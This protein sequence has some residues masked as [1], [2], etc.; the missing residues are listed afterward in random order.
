MPEARSSSYSDLLLSIAVAQ[1]KRLDAR[2]EIHDL[3]DE[4]NQTGDNFAFS[5]DLVLKAGLLL[6]DIGNVGFKVENFNQE[7]MAILEER[8]PQVKQ[9]LILTVRLVASFGFNGQNLRASSAILPIAYYLWRLAPGDRYLTTASF[10]GDRQ[11]V[12]VWLTKSI[13]KSSGIWGSGLDTLLTILRETIQ[14]HGQAEFPVDEIEAQMARR[15]KSLAFEAEEI[16]ELVE[17]RYGDSRT[18]ALLSLLFSFVDFHNRFHIDH[19][20]PRAHFTKPRL[21]RDGFSDIE[22]DRFQID[23]GR[24]REPPAA[25]WHGEHREAT[26]AAVRVACE[27]V[28]GPRQ[29]RQLLCEARPRQAAR[30]SVWFLGFLHVAGGGAATPDL[31]VAREVRPS[32]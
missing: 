28:R 15:G 4:L 18:F 26:D 11:R 29:P 17:L 13:L 25:G 22:I 2:Q 20:F 21:K 5:Q 14:Q 27:D 16:E 6:T 24:A 12:R 10:S 1:W 9:A 23:K 32:F 19:I 8:W 3:V 31:P 30:R 7:N